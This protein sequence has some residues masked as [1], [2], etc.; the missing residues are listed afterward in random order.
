MEGKFVGDDKES[1][2]PGPAPAT[3][4]DRERKRQRWKSFDGGGCPASV[5]F[6]IG[7]DSRYDYPDHK[8]RLS[9]HD[10]RRLRAIPSRACVPECGMRQM[11]RVQLQ[12]DHIWR[13][14]K[15]VQASR[16]ILCLSPSHLPALTLP[17][18]SPGIFRVD[19]NS[20]SL[21]WRC[22]VGR[23]KK[24]SGWWRERSQKRWAG[25][26][27][28]RRKLRKELILMFMSVSLL[29]FLTS[30][31]A[32]S[33]SFCSFHFGEAAAAAAVDVLW[34]MTGLFLSVRPYWAVPSAPSM[35]SFGEQTFTTSTTTTTSRS[36]EEIL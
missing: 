32:R 16:L 28:R 12:R 22:D 36:C 17:F 7:L 1:C 14:T 13:Q 26:I 3:C 6:S 11:K 35:L 21:E 34:T 20:K 4:A 23:S 10:P 9:F 15:K 33:W 18:L 8:N 25:I 2:D 19:S 5:A 24:K 29:G 31:G 27:N 30:F